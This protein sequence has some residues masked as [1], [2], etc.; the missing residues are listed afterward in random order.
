MNRLVKPADVGSLRPLIGLAICT[1]L[2]VVPVLAQTFFG[3]IVGTATDSSGAS[4][5]GSRVVLT[6]TATNE[7]RSAETDQSGNYQFLNL[8]PGKYRVDLEKAGFKHFTKDQIEV[9]VQ[10]SVRVDIL[11]QVGDVG[12]TVEVN[13][14]AVAL[15]TETATI[16][17]AVQGRN[18]TDMPLNGRN[19]YSLVALV[20]GVVIEAAG[21]P[22]IGGGLANQNA[23]YVDG[24]SMNTGYFNQTVAAPTQDSIEEFRVQTNAATAEFGRYAGG[25]ITLSSKSGTN[26]FHG[27]A[28]EFLRNKVLNANPFFSNRSGLA[29]VPF[30]QNQ[31]GGTM[32]GPIRKN[33]TF[34]FASY[35]GFFQR[36][37]TTYVLNTPTDQMRGGDFGQLLTAPGGPTTIYDPLSSKTGA[38]RTPFPG[39][40]IPSDRLD[41]TAVIMS[42]IQW[43]EPNQPGLTNNFVNNASSGS[44]NNTISGRVDHTLSDKQRLFARYNYAAPVPVLVSPYHNS[45]YTFGTRKTPLM[46]A[47]VGDTWTFS[48]SLIGDL[49]LSYLRN[50]NTR[51]PDQLGIDLTTV[52]WPASYN[53][54]DTTRTLP[55]IC[56]TNYD[57]LAGAQG[58]YC[59][60]NPQSVIVVTNNVYSLSPS[61]TKVAG[62]HTLKFG[63]ELR[64]I[65]LNYLQAN[66]NSG[67]FSFTNGMTAQNALSP[68]ATGYSFA[69]F[70][71][72]Y[73][74]INTGTNAL[75]LNAATTGLE[76]YQGYYVTDTFVVNRK[77]TLTYGL[78][79]E[80]LG[81]FYERY[82]R[83]TVLQP[84]AQNP[85]VPNLG[86][87]A[88]VSSSNYSDRGS[89]PHPWNLF[90]PRLGIAYR[91]SDKWV[92]RAGG[93]ISFLP[94]DGNIG[95]SPFG[96][97]VNSINTPWVPSLDGG[98]T[99]FATLSNPFP[100]GITPPPQRSPNYAQAL[101][102]L[103]VTS[104]EPTNPH[105]YTEQYNFSVQREL[106]KGAL[107]EVTY[108]A[109]KGVHLYRYPGMELNQLPDQYL[110]LGAQLLQQVPNPYYGKV[111]VGTLASPNVAY[112]QL[113]RPFPQYTGFRYTNAADGNSRYD[114]LQVKLEKR[115]QKGGAL[116]ASYTKSKLISD[117]EQQAAFTSG[118][119]A[120]VA[121]DYY[122]LRAER[123]LA[124]YDTPENLVVSYV[125][126]L[127]VGKGRAFL[128]N[129][130]GP[131]DKL[132]SGWGIN[133]ITT[134]Q[135]G[136]PLGF[137]L[138]TNNSNSFGGNPRPN[139]AAGCSKSI[140][141]SAQSRVNGWFNTGCFTAPTAFTF[142]SESRTDPNLRTAGVANWDF[143]AF[144]DTAIHERFALQF[145]A[146]IFNMFNR[147]QFAAPN[148]TVGSSTFGYV[149][150]QVNN[151]R[152]VQ[153]ALRL[154]F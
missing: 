95:S 67:N 109:L 94:T 137:V 34:F 104:A 24:V 66:N 102:G 131:L 116:L 13:A 68:G 49:R 146:E 144:K 118:V 3:S 117:L 119:G 103:A 107:L 84:G 25:V 18:V 112:G 149:T 96:S 113:L 152:L 135:S 71:L 97:P 138:A 44:T 80:G 153:V 47:V 133:G 72:G 122:N 37:A 54:Q 6:N 86:Q 28:Y 10:A 29:R 75:T 132:V 30:T 114:S 32:G 140:S 120:Y 2:L 33:K 70:M 111:A 42:K 17:Q 126:D 16:S 27:T 91:L 151:P 81:P 19:V 136:N 93:G 78:R 38:N 143:A 41:R 139:V 51:Y 14:E 39:N 1:A 23:T 83:Q 127:P 88:Q 124:A 69:S 87:V 125:Y 31:F 36:T 154:K 115:F 85:L 98:L 77:L 22:Q 50:H 79:W 148:T 64:R 7:T 55:Q 40:I 45:E 35:E 128:G 43:N 74:A 11:M 12:Q 46:T 8:V 145:R 61:L 65:E 99:P 48:P 9:L 5:P 92:I 63:V 90:A 89:G 134:L 26:E 58:G 62:R 60:G 4:V 129:L 141:G 20:P 147:V 105:A 15:Q 100:N 73:G 110:S 106:P 82:D 76:T 56:V 142:G 21:A 123:S 57:F 121:Q 130:P 101:L 108:A 53:L 150:N 59:Q 52:G